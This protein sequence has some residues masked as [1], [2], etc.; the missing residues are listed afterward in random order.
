MASYPH[1]TAAEL[2]AGT[3]TSMRVVSPKVLAD[4]IDRRVAAAIA[5]HG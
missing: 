4:E 3:D 2:Q 1:M 5:A